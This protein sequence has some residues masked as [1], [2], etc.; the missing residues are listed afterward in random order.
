MSPKEWAVISNENAT[1]KSAF[2]EAKVLS[3]LAY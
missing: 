1:E 2:N 3:T